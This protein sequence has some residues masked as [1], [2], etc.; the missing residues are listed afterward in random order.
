M[1]GYLFKN[2]KERWKLQDNEPC[3]GNFHLS[4]I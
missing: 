3:A 2:N 1:P 4:S